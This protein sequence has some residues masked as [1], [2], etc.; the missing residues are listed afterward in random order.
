MKLILQVMLLVVMLAPAVLA[1]T[2]GKIVGHVKDAQTKESLVGVNVLVQGTSLGAATDLEGYYSI[3]NV[4][5]GSHIVIASAIG[6]T[7]KTVTDLTVSVDFTTTL[8][9]DMAAT[10]V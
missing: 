7:K 9:L 8:A 4:P 1:G 5:P 10:L 3:L 6:Y 2:T